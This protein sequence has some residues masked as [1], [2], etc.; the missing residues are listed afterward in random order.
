[1]HALSCADMLNGPEKYE[2]VQVSRCGFA[3]PF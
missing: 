1:M 3:H 2:T